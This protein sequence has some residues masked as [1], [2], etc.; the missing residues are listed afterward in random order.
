MR[1]DLRNRLI[2]TAFL[3]ALLA[4]GAQAVA[5]EPTPAATGRAE[6][7][8][9]SGGARAA[10]ARTTKPSPTPNA[11]ALADKTAAPAASSRRAGSPATPAPA[12]GPKTEARRGRGHF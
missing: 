1:F 11:A 5:A 12:T 9:Q 10:A 8:H 6:S 7:R 3:G 2:R 4:G